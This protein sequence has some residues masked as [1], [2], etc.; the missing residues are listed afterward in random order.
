MSYDKPFSEKQ[1][2]FFNNANHRYN[3]KTGATRSG[4][5]YMDYYVIPQRIRAR[6]GKEGLTVILG[7]TNSTIERN[8][9]RP[10]REMYGE[11][12][13]GGIRKGDNIATLFGEEVYCLGAEKVSQ[14][15]KIRGAS[16]KYCYGDEVAEWNREVFELLKSRLDKPYSVFDGALNP[17]SPYHWLKEFL[18]SDADIYQQQYTIFDNP[19]LPQKF[20]DDLCNEYAGTVYYKRYI[21]GEWA[22]AEG[23][24]YDMFSEERHVKNREEIEEGASYYVSCDYGTQNATCFLLWTKGKD[25]KWYCIKEYYYSGR[26]KGTQKTDAEYTE[27]MKKFC[28]GLPIREVVVDPSASSFIASLRQAGF[29]VVKANNDVM[30]GIRNVSKML[31]LNQIYFSKDCVNL[32]KEFNGYV[33][34]E[35]QVEKGIDAPIKIND[36]AMDAM[37]YF[38]HTILVKQKA[39]VGNKA[40]IGVY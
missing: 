38:V 39:I 37:R 35:K 36:H 6:K 28:E 8:I 2:E 16:I 33:W 9:L 18:D 12:L 30:D 7:V 10:M 3:I 27:D 17:Q 19:F 15:S 24:I 29:S 26:D 5:T 11:E 32:I 34:D 1:Y 20:V 13:V 23:R 21:L 31:N 22:L 40:R 4:K 25:G 14:V